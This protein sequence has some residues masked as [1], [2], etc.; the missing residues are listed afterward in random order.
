MASN[1]GIFNY[2]IDQLPNSIEITID[3]CNFIEELYDKDFDDCTC[4]APMTG[5][6]AKNCIKDA[7][8]FEDSS[9][10]QKTIVYL[11]CGLSLS[12]PVL[13]LVACL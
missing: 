2:V 4:G 11:L 5:Q 13:A 3:V 9:A 8:D 1:P 7:I 10:F 6:A 12:L